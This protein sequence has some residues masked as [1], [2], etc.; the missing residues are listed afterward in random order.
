M[1]PEGL[2]ASVTQRA[3]NVRVVVL[4]VDGV[5][6]DGGL[7]YTRDG[8]T[9]KRFQ[10]RDGLGVRLLLDSGVEVAVISARASAPLERRIRDLGIR[11]FLPGSRDKL[12][13]L[14]ELIA[15]LNVDASAV[16]FVGDDLLDV[17]ALRAVGLAVA[18]A[19]GHPVVQREAHW[20]TRAEG[21]H[22]AVREVADLILEAQQGLMVAYDRH[23]AKEQERA[24]RPAPSHQ[25]PSFGVIIPARFSSTRLPGKPL[26]DL[27]GRPM[28]CY[29]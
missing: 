18:V 14:D 23:L 22:G 7:Q 26:R 6:T 17:P 3:R 5:L 25:Q 24:R 2:P 29:K 10:V 20:V 28:D 16:C 15:R 9:L 8:E 12:M 4:D 13:A 21:G 11:H 27:A 19:D 1:M